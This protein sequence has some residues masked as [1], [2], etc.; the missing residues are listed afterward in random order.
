MKALISASR[1]ARDRHLVGHR[2]LRHGQLVCRGVLQQLRHRRVRVLRRALLG[3]LVALPLDEPAAHGV[4]LL[5]QQH[6]VTRHQL[7]GHRVRVRE[8]ALRRVVDDV[9]ERGV[10]RGG[11]EL[12]REHLIGLL[13]QLVEERGIDGGGLLADD[14][15]EGSALGAVADA[16]GAEAAEQVN[17]ERSGLGEL[18]GGKLGAALVEVVGDPH[19]TNGVRARWAG[20]HFVELFDRRHDRPLGLL[21]H[22]QVRRDV[23]LGGWRR[24]RC[25]R[26]GTVGRG[27]RWRA[28]DD[29]AGGTDDGRFHQERAPIDAG[30]YLDGGQVRN[31]REQG[32]AVLLGF[33]GCALT[34][35]R[36]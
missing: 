9:L 12:H 8:V 27:R 28:A 16:R 20:T 2:H 19:R 36:E 5:L 32:F 21:D 35:Y 33:H 25:W 7:A 30:G 14:A 22:V 23:F 3:R 31:W 11:A 6:G 24:R 18:V 15:G 34:D 13:L 29:H 4:V 10:E 1:L 26:R 17:L